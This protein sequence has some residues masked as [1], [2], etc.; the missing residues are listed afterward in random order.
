[1][2]PAQFKSA[3][4]ETHAHKEAIEKECR[5]F[6]EDAGPQ[7]LISITPQHGTWAVALGCRRAGRT[8]LR[9]S[10]LS[11]RA[12]NMEVIGKWLR[13]SA[14]EIRE[15][16]ELQFGMMPVGNLSDQAASDLV[17]LVGLFGGR[18]HP[19]GWITL[20][21]EKSWPSFLTRVEEAGITLAASVRRG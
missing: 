14:R 5:R 6:L 17:D 4:P 18:L 13:S 10:R 3:I 12:Q 16:A 20:A 2:I 9:S 21:D 19:D 15:E 7:W 1:V 11:E 8:V